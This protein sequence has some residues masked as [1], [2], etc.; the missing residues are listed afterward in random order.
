MSRGLLPFGEEGN[1]AGLLCFKVEGGD[2]DRWP[3]TYW[4]YDEPE[5]GRPLLFSSFDMLLRCTT[6]YLRLFAETP[7]LTVPRGRDPR[8]A[9]VIIQTDPEGAGKSGAEYWRSFFAS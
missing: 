1:D 6:A 8:M 3:V 5:A 4:D 9:E 7:D 2:P